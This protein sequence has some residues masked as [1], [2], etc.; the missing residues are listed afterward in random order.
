MG[1]NRQDSVYL[2]KGTGDE[3]MKLSYLEYFLD[4]VKFGSISKAAE[5]NY[6]KH[7]KS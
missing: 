1:E 4:V 5:A 7:G 3:S 6:L 2:F